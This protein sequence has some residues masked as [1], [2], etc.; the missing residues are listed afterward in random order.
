MIDESLITHIWPKSPISEAYRV[1]RTNLQFTGLDTPVKVIVVTS[2]GP[3]EGKTTTIANMAITF[4]QSGVKVLVIDG[5]LRKPKVN[6]LFRI[7]N[8][9][10]FTNALTQP[11]NLSDFIQKSETEG[12]DI[13]ASGPIPP[14]PSE[15]LGSNKMKVLLNTLK[16]IYDMILIDTPPVRMLTDAQILAALADGTIIV[17]ASGQVT[18]EALKRAKELLLNVNANIIGVIVNKLERETNGYYYYTYYK[19]YEEEETLN[20]KRRRKRASKK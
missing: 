10:G 5:D 20:N 8:K 3:S 4:A 1:L 13:L 11:Q 17:A 9:F 18:F 19:H 7:S 12:L 6:K 16:E 14:N 2:S 15:L